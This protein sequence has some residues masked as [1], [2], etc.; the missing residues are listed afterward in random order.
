MQ[1]IREKLEVKPYNTISKKN[2]KTRDITA[3]PSGKI[4]KHKYLTGEEIVTT[5]QSQMIE[6][7]KFTH[8]FLEKT[9]DKTTS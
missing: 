4:F 1:L 9:T 3:L 2:K 5:N 8:S 6:Q 7:V